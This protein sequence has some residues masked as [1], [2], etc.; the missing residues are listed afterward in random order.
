MATGNIN[1]KSKALKARVPHNVVEAMESVKKADESTA[2]FIV[3][4]MQTEIE[5]RLK[6]KK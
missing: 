1:A 4:S 5:R 6:D 2:Q 3:T